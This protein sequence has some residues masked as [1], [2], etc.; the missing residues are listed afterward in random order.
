MIIKPKAIAAEK[1]KKEEF[2]S[3]KPNGM[4]TPQI[5]DVSTSSRV[6]T[7]FYNSYNFFDSA[8]D[9]LM[10]GCAA[11]SILEC[12][13]KSTATAKIKHA[14]FHNLTMLPGKINVLEE[15]TIDGITGIYF[16]TKMSETTLGNDT[17]MNYMDKVYDNHSIGYRYTN[18]QYIERE[19]EKEWNAI[20][21]LLINPEAAEGHDYLFAVKEIQ[22]FEGSTVAYGCNSLTP[23]LGMKS[24]TS[25]AFKLQLMNKVIALEKTLRKGSQSEDMMN[26]LNL[27]CLQLKQVLSELC[28]MIPN[29]MITE[30]EKLVDMNKPTIVHTSKK[31]FNSGMLS[32]IDLK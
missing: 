18:L 3:I 19:S 5:K 8:N 25:D 7:G 2:Y 17:L 28:D 9:V 1:Q 23:F 30:K 29:E 12:G 22:L 27:Q 6:V 20:M 26:S 10:N 14:M 4:I 24:Q 21:Q 32:K 15:K 31:F 11:K 16:E 13:P